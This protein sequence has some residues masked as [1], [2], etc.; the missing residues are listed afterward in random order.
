MGLRLF[1]PAIVAG[2]LASA[3]VNA[4]EA[5]LPLNIP[6]GLLTEALRTFPRQAAVS[7]LFDPA[8]TAGLRTSG[9]SGQLSPQVA[10]NQLL[11]G[12]GLGYRRL[13]NGSYVIV[14]VG[15]DET[16]PPHLLQVATEPT[17]VPEVL[18][19]GR[20]SLNSDIQRRPDDIQ[21]YQVTTGAQLLA[22]QSTSVE[23]YLRSRSPSN[24]ELLAQVQAPVLNHGSARSEINLGGLGSRQTLVLVD[25]R[26]LPS[27]PVVG[28]FLQS[29]LNAIPPAAIERIETLTSTASGIYGPGAVGGVIN[30]VLKRNYQGLELSV[31]SGMSDQGDSRRWRLD[32][33]LGASSVTGDT[34]VMMAL[35]HAEDDGLLV[36]QRDFIERSR[37]IRDRN[38]VLFYAPSSPSI[39]IKGFSGL[40]IVGGPVL[41]DDLTFVPAVAGLA[42]GDLSVLL[43]N[44]GKIDLR[45]SPDGAGTLQS[46]IS[47]TTIS[48]GVVSL[49]QR[50]GD[51]I[52]LFLDA[53]YL[54]EKGTAAGPWI[55]PAVANVAPGANGNPFQ[56]GIQVSFPTPGLVGVSST[57][58]RTE[59]LTA[60][61]I[62][63]LYH[64]WSAELDL[65]LA[66]GRTDTI[67]F[68]AGSADIFLSQTG[69]DLFGGAASL[70]AGLAAY[71]HP[72]ASRS[73]FV[74]TMSDVNLRLAGPLFRTAAGTATLTF[75]AETRRQH[76]PNIAALDPATVGTGPTIPLTGQTEQVESA[77]A[78]LRAPII[79]I[80]GSFWLIRGLE[81]QAA[82]RVDRFGIE[83][84]TIGIGAASVLGGDTTVRVG[85]RTSTLTAGFKAR[86]IDG[87]LVRASYSTGYLP[88]SPSQL[89]PNSYVEPMTQT[90]YAQDPKRPGDS[91][92]ASN[93]VFVLVDGSPHLKPERAIT[94][95][96]GMVLT[97]AWAPGLRISVDY[98]RIKKSQEIVLP[99][100]GE[101]ADIYTLEDMYPGIV[102]RG[103]LTAE[104]IAK[105]YAVGPVV[106]FDG[107]LR[108]AGYSTTKIVDINL[109]YRW[110]TPIGVVRFYGQAVWQPSLVRRTT[111]LADAYQVAGRLDGPLRVRGNAG[112]DWSRGRWQAALNLQYYGQYRITYGAS[113]ILSTQLSRD[114][115]Y[116]NLRY[117][118]AEM[119][120]SQTYV[121][122]TL[123]YAFGGETPTEVRLGVRNLLGA[124]PPTVSIPLQPHT[125][126]F[127]DQGIGYSPYGDPR[128]RRVEVSISRRF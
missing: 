88:P 93:S 16:H 118:G 121:D 119:I 47:S 64:D 3:P 108:N 14:R 18:V 24:A 2:A 85:Q 29:D 81:L 79:P 58:I 112:L 12:S 84:P 91:I 45:L 57:D 103:P 5:V 117:Q 71:D 9:I 44:A 100:N 31:A 30:V 37:I 102:R 49:R 8:M 66:R 72:P 23:D 105:G 82:A 115:A 67:S 61:A 114:G 55:T 13:P 75:L 4:A 110:D 76:T 101:Y 80:D 46:A 65:T 15:P 28:D 52:E 26:R 89:I 86:P 87:V 6:P 128:G 107:S 22:A 63:R 1:W 68:A 19:I 97:P 104:D 69:V 106:F 98:T 48:S 127:A 78:E 27:I 73:V 39:N 32:G 77:Y 50:L 123:G 125:G 95:S 59:R 70:Q 109:G 96:A 92:A 60:G 53:L 41:P 62:T 34:R 124:R 126:P 94:F 20:R 11:A 83:V 7:L 56:Y 122:A 36:G 90:D 111:P 113:D 43:A 38:G 17:T 42:N 74:N 54:D 99:T 120:P 40:Q 25:G 51:R 35:S 21:P 116:G 33:S 10:L